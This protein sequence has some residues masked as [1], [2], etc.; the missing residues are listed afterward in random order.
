MT[1]ERLDEP[2]VQFAVVVPAAAVASALRVSQR[3][4]DTLRI[5]VFTVDPDGTVGQR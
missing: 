5:A 1:D 2:D 3:V 4:R